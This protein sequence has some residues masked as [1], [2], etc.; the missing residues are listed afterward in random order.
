MIVNF[1][2]DDINRAHTEWACFCGPAA[3]AV[4]CNLTLD[5]T[6]EHFPGFRGWTNPTMMHTAL[7]SLQR[8]SGARWH[9]VTENAKRESARPT[10]PRNGLARIQSAYDAIEGPAI[11]TVPNGFDAEN[12]S[13]E[14]LK[15]PYGELFSL[16]TEES[17]VSNDASLVKAMLDA[18][19][20]MN[21]TLDL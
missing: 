19:A 15:T 9:K 16:L 21:I 4:V 2:H 17:D 20:A 5:E 7:V 11:P 14:H 6:R 18:A 12:P 10:W 1:T 13:A 3:F 8:R